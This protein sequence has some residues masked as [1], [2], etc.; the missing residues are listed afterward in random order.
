MSNQSGRV[1]AIFLIAENGKQAHE[2]RSVA[3]HPGRGLEGD[4]H[5]DDAEACDITLIEAEAIERQ[6]AEHPLDLS[7]SD[8]R[9]QVVVRGVDLGQFIGRR[10]SVGEIEC[11]G[12]ERCEPCNHLAGVIGTEVVKLKGLVHTG[13][14]ASIVKGGTIRTGDAVAMTVSVSGAAERS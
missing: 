6:N 10:F 11:E 2:V 12:E 1:E 3:A 8:P 7:Q 9:R 5:F 13:L 4:R 14:R